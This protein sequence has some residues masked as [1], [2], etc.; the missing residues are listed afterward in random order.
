MSAKYQHLPHIDVEGYYQ[1]IT[2]RTQDSTD[3]FLRRLATQDMPNNKKQLAADEH[4]DTSQRGAYLNG[5]V[6]TA[7]NTF[8][9][10]KE[11]ELYQLIAFSIMPNHVHLLIKPHEK[12]PVVM[13]RIKGGSAKMINELLGRRGPF[14]ARDYYDKAIRDERHFDVVYQYIKNN[15]LKLGAAEAALPRFYSIPE[16]RP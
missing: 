1:F 15:P 5:Q 3:G 7:L 9:K 16:I 12:L 2:F 8:L 4:I 10:E 13:Q 6:L 11:G 14:W